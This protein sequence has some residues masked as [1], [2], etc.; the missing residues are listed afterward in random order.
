MAGT[1]LSPRAHI[2]DFHSS[3][4]TREPHW[5]Y[6]VRILPCT[7]DPGT[8]EYLDAVYCMHDVSMLYTW[9]MWAVILGILLIWVLARFFWPSR[10]ISV[11]IHPDEEGQ[12]VTAPTSK[13]FR[14][15]GATV[16]FVRHWLLSEGLTGVFGHV[17]RLQIAILA[18]ISGY[19]LI[20]S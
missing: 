9:I 8:C 4:T 11:S 5:G 1:H 18:L 16:A 19:L 17:S 15:F 10:G 20:F 13:L 12:K 14:P 3:N 7:N 2:Q 6:A